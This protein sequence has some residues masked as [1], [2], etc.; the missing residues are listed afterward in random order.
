VKSGTGVKLDKKA[1]FLVFFVDFLVKDG[2]F[3]YALFRYGFC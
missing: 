2:I 1:G 3:I